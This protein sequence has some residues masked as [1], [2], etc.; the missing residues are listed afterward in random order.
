MHLSSDLSES[1]IIPKIL[2]IL[3]SPRVG[4]TLAYQVSINHFD[5]YY[6]SN[7]LNTLFESG[8]FDPLELPKN[9]KNSQ[10]VNYCSNYGKT[11]GAD[12]PS[13]AS[14]LFR[15]F[16]WRQAPLRIK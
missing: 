13:E 5:V 11:Q 4:S 2:F 14:A 1:S 7:H 9:I 15:H 12:Q 16:F 8:K 10:F 6:P 3:G